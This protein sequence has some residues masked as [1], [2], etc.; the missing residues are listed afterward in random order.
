MDLVLRPAK[1]TDYP[2]FS[3]WFPTL[4]SGDVVPPRT[5]WVDDMGP[6]STIAEHDG[7]PVGYCYAQTLER[8]GYVRHLAVD[9]SARGQGVGRAL[10]EH[11]AVG[12]RAAGCTRWRLNVKPDNDPAVGLYSALG[13]TKVHESA[14]LRFDW[15]IL[16]RLPE[17]PADRTVDEPDAAEQSAIEQRF[18]LPAGQLASAAA[19]EGVAVLAVRSTDTMLGVA[20]FDVGFPG[21]FPFRAMTVED[22]NALLH[23]LHPLATQH[24]MGLVAEAHPQLEAALVEAGARVAF[25][26]MHM[27]GPL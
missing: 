10:L 9:E 20:A 24:G 26:F 16:E 3:R 21:C 6:Q 22:A 5:A 8:D 27:S 14:S 11:A 15:S 23:G 18:A 7:E 13:M 19:R 12:M 25:R 2:H 1:P 17:P 4:G